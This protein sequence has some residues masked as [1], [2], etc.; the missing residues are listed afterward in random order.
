M[1][2]SN[3]LDV[4]GNIDTADELGDEILG[5]INEISIDHLTDAEMINDLDLS[6]LFATID[7][8][9]TEITLDEN[10]QFD[11]PFFVDDLIFKDSFDGVE[12]DEFG[13]WFLNEEQEIP[14]I[15]DHF[16]EVVAEKGIM[17]ENGFVNE[18]LIDEILE[19][20]VLLDRDEILGD[21]NF[22]MLS[23]KHNNECQSTAAEV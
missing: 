5:T 11:D 2:V 23:L 16:E 21:V 6:D 4:H 10:L 22:G 19:K 8:W 20:A 15:W 12:S 7:V 14:E 3:T 1:F 17:V 9:N 18:M 13:K